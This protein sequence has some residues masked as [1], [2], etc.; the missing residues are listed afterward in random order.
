MRMS[1]F[2]RHEVRPS[3]GCT[4]PACVALAVAR[5]ASLLKDRDVKRLSR[6]EL[7]LSE[8]VYKNG[9][10]VGIPGGGGLRGNA[11]AAALGFVGGD[12]S[13]ELEVLARCGELERASALALLEGGKVL[14]RLSQEHKGLYVKACLRM[15]DGEE[16]TCTVQGSHSNV[17]EMSLNG[18]AVAR[19]G[20]QASGGAVDRERFDLAFSELSFHDLFE[21]LHTMGEEDE[22]FLLEG[23]S[24]NVEVGEY[25]LAEGAAPAGIGRRTMEMALGSQGAMALGLRIRALCAAAS[26]VR[27]SGA[28]KT[29]M[30][31]AGSG[32]HGI[33][34]TIP[35]YVVG[36]ERGLDRRSIA[37]GLG[38]SHLV[39]SYVKNALGRLSPT[40][41]CA[42]AAGSGAA[43]GI[44][45]MLSRD[46][47]KAERAAVMVVANL[48]GMLCDGAKESCALKVGSAAFEAYSAAMLV[49]Q[50]VELHP[51]QGVVGGN[52][53]DTV[54]AAAMVNRYGMGAVDKVVLDVL[55]GW[56]S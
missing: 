44:A 19:E 43:A 11:V 20:T 34:A 42:V 24:M 26:E 16:A 4:E 9:A 10:A 25:G 23:A 47:A 40:C 50:G 33:T 35:V 46:R 31:S 28:F 1:Y 45:Y 3:L 8:S 17:V 32:N 18:K 51:F 49:L 2:L 55:A 56:P 12:P 21:V 29:V 27:M 13:L 54:R 52:L 15:A 30:S 41:G 22:R 39:T 36:S 5:A 7:H 37:E 53:E 6:I 14:V 48:L 38:L